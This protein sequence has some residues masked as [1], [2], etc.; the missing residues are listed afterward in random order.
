MAAAVVLMQGVSFPRAA[1]AVTAWFVQGTN[2]SFPT[3]EV[4]LTPLLASSISAFS[5]ET[6]LPCHDMGD[7]EFNSAKKLHPSFSSVPRTL[8]FP[9]QMISECTNLE[10]RRLREYHVLCE[11]NYDPF[12]D[13]VNVGQSI[14]FRKQEIHTVLP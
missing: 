12:L 2:L 13:K 9:L 1:A 3:T 6:T 7:V 10:G 8:S 11:Q 4:R 5:A 14:F